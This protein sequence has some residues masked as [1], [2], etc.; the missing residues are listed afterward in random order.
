MKWKNVSALEVNMRP[1]EN[2][3]PPRV[4][5]LRKPKLRSK[6]PLN[7]PKV[8]PTAEARL[9]MSDA[10]VADMLICLKVSLKIKP[11]LWSTGTIMIYKRRDSEH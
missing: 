10:S 4:A 8:I 5:T 11:K 9:M 1:I 6:G 2:I 7:R 3:H